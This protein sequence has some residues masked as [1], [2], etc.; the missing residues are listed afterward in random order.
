MSILKWSV[1][2]SLLVAPFV[3]FAQETDSARDVPKQCPPEFIFLTFWDG[4]PNNAKT[5]PVNGVKVGL[6]FTIGDAPVK[7][8]DA[9]IF[10]ALSKDVRGI[11]CALFSTMSQHVD[12]VQFSLF[13]YAK[14]CYGLQI[15]IF[16]CN[17]EKGAVQ[18]GLLNHKKN[19][20]FCP[21]FPIINF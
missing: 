11:Q 10:Y 5:T 17:T 9:S 21:I 14:K 6:P 2:L 13:N 8:L 3:L 4:F 20:S 1:G 18:F 7:G 19:S 12:G 15:G 16:N